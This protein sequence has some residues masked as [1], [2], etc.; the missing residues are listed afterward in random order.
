MEDEGDPRTAGQVWR[1]FW[2]GVFAEMDPI[3]WVLA[4]AT[5]VGSVFGVLD[6]AGD[7]D[8]QREWGSIPLVGP[9]I[10]A[11][12]LALSLCWRGRPESFPAA[13]IRC[14]VVLPALWC[15][16]FSV[17][18]SLTGSLPA[19]Q[20]MAKAAQEANHGFHYWADEAFGWPA[21]PLYYFA[22]VGLSGFFVVMV[23]L[24]ITMPYLAVRGRSA[25]ELG[26][27]A[28][29][30]GGRRRERLMVTA[31]A[32]CLSCAVIGVVL[33]VT[34]ERTASLDLGTRLE[35]AVAAFQDPYELPVLGSVLGVLFLVLA[36]VL[37][38]VAGWARR[39]KK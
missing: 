34:T 22:G 16:P 17:A 14:G 20:A 23:I 2:A 33:L 30:A 12:Y 5:L 10:F 7:P 19:V 1:D 27:D 8:H 18:A 37:L 25:S 39:A 13:I 3:A 4:L 11:S 31:A 28:P 24:V 36:G 32:L 26:F 38:V 21:L 15:V 9:C 35:R 6:A 29:K